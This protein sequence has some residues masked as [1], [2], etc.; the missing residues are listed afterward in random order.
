MPPKG[1]R[2]GGDGGRGAEARRRA[3]EARGGRAR[4][5]E[6]ETTTSS[7]GRLRRPCATSLPASGSSAPFRTCSCSGSIVTFWPP[8]LPSLICVSWYQMVC[9]C[10]SQ[11]MVQV[12]SSRRRR[13]SCWRA[14]K[15][16]SAASRVRSLASA[17]SLLWVPKWLRVF[18]RFWP[19]FPI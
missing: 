13:S 18:W 9:R 14:M 19:W 12:S 11:T 10:C 2:S 4:G 16:T 17:L 3:V 15:E 5:A 1:R 8:F 7:S 6:A